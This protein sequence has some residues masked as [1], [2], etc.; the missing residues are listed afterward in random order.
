LR[1]QYLPRAWKQ[2]HL[3]GKKKTTR[4]RRRERRDN[5]HIVIGEIHIG[6]WMVREK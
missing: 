2:T 5:S 6:R 3:K 4:K 1:E